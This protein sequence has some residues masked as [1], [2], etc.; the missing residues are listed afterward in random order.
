M[1]IEQT[2]VIKRSPV[3]VIMGHVDH[4]KSTL[5]DYIRKSNIV[6]GEAGGITQHI[7]AYEVEHKDD[8]GEAQKITFIDTPGHAAFTSMRYRG[9]AVADIAILVVSAEDS[10]KAQTVEAIKTILDKKVPYIVAINKIDRPNANVEKVKVDLLEHGVFV[11]GY[12]GSTPVVPISAKAGT[13]VSDLLDMILLLADLENFTHNPNVPGEGLVIESHLDKNRGVSATLIIKQ[14]TIPKGGFIVIEDSIASTRILENF[15]GK[16]IIEP[17][18][19]SPIGVI[20][21]DSLPRVGA[22]FESFATK[23]EAEESVRIYRD[24]AGK[25]KQHIIDDND[26]RTCIPLIIKGDTFGSIEAIEGE[27]EKRTNEYIIFKVIKTGIGDINESDI[28]LAVSSPNS[29]ILGFHV[30]EGPQVSGMDERQ[31][32]TIKMFDIIYKLTEWIEEE[33]EKRTVKAPVETVTGK[34]KVLKVFSSTK[35]GTVVGCRIDEGELKKNQKV[36]IKKSDELIGTGV[37]S[38]LKLGKIETD[39][40]REGNECGILIDSNVEFTG[41]EVLSVITL[42]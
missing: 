14:G 18:A 38:L 29:I 16:T 9:A 37:I 25:K 42:S 21:F 27:I 41:G 5:L 11:E 12:G 32:V 6:A 10:V 2:S 39:I 36:T 31:Y 40:I 7:S 3:V 30:K 8:K 35:H 19:S 26:T 17:T 4:G 24:M 15:L 33:R 1:A 28:Q 13:G 34:A 20:G 23:K 22:F